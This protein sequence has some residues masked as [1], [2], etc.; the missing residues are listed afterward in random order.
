MKILTIGGAT[1]DVFIQYE[2]SELLYLEKDGSKKAFL[3]LEEGRKIEVN[4]LTYHSGGGATNSAVSFKRLGLEVTTFFKVGNDENGEFILQELQHEGVG[5]SLVMRTSDFPTGTSF[6][7][8]SATGERT[9]LAY[10]GANAHLTVNEIPFNTIEQ[11]DHLYITSLSGA[12]SALLVPITEHAKKHNVPVAVNPGGSQLRAGAL[13]LQQALK[14]IDILIMNATE[15]ELFMHSL[16]KKKNVF[17]NRSAF[18]QEVLSRG[19]RIVVMTNGAQ[20]VYAA[21]AEGIYFHPSIPSAIVNTV[22]AGDAFGS[23]FVASIVQKKPIEKALLYGILNGTSVIAH[24][25]AKTGLLSEHEL[26]KRAQ[27]HL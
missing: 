27:N 13:L 19:P 2:N 3:T 26:V 9:V 17:F 6:I 23:T 10:R 20:G 7:I 11:Q 15:A 12:S 5:T 4:Q 25:G 18:F 22:G 1:Q 24:M 8:P 14:N 16:V 21:T